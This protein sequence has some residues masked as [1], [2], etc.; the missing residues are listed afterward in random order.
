MFGIKLRHV[1]NIT[2]KILIR[3]L[4]NRR[5]LDV[6]GP[7]PGLNKRVKAFRQQG[8]KIEDEDAEEFMEE[9]SSTFY[10]VGEAYTQHLN[11][12]LMGKLDLPKKIVKEKYFKENTPNLLTWS[13]KEQIRH[14][15]TT[16]PDEW[17]LERI[18]ESFPVTVQTAKKLLKYP[19][20]P[21]TEERIA[22]HDASAMR[23][24]RE[25]KDG[26]LN[27]PE[28]LRQHFLKF[29]E[30]KI[31]PLNKTSIKVDLT[32]SHKMGEFEQIIH[33]C[34]NKDNVENGTNNFKK[35]EHDHTDSSNNKKI[36]RDPQR[37]TL[38]D[39]TARIRKRLESGNNVEA[40]DQIIID[41]VKKEEFVNHK[42]V[43]VT[44]YTPKEE[45]LEEYQEKS[46]SMEI[47]GYPERIRIPKKAYKKGATY[48][49]KD[50]Y[51]DHDGKFLYRVIGVSE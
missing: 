16:H 7:N 35:S 18:A 9:S 24:W 48:K 43:E 8:V 36:V 6:T 47:V 29:S 10:N 5:Q 1:I 17:T 44:N 33:R 28:D 41:T 13:E 23:N 12:T 14:L 45:E 42:T 15:V 51:Y 46:K 20:K 30:R 40:S 11:E 2:E 50:C 39:L 4:R 22:R 49:L 19:W 25:L 32:Q 26:T 37:M 34:S 21:A 27:I 31:P 3:N 38:E